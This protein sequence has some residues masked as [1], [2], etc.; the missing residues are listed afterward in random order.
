MELFGLELGAWREMGLGLV[1]LTE[2]Q[3]GARQGKALKN[4][5]GNPEFQWGRREA[6]GGSS[7]D[8]CR[9]RLAS[10]SEGC[11]AVA[12]ES[13]QPTT[14]SLARRQA[15][16]QGCGER[17]KQ[18]GL[19][20]RREGPGSQAHNSGSGRW[21]CPSWRWGNTGEH[22]K[23]NFRNLLLYFS[24]RLIFWSIRTNLVVKYLLNLCSF[25]R[26]SFHQNRFSLVP[27]E[28]PH[29]SH[30]SS[31]FLNVMEGPLTLLSFSCL[32]TR[33]FIP[34]FWYFHISVIQ[35]YYFNKKNKNEGSSG[36]VFII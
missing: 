9:R 20:R 6:P 5:K 24:P 26:F 13:G 18:A 4:L 28:T 27:K 25:K 29:A 10:S 8:C 23:F 22:G 19:R 30:L 14:A 17:Q 3:A 12:W 7:E 31:R 35:T 1:D 16:T 33:H 34:V 15:L 32:M 11:A 2:K 21:W 36:D